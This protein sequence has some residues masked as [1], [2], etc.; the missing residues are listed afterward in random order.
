MIFFGLPSDNYIAVVYIVPENSN[1]A[2]HDPFGLLQNDIACIPPGCQVL[3]CGDYNAHTSVESDFMVNINE[4]WDGELTDYL[5]N[6]NSER[7]TKIFAM[8]EKNPLER[9]SQDRRNVDNYGK[10]LLK[11]CKAVGMLILNGRLGADKGIGRY[12]RM[13][14]NSAS[15]VDYVIVTPDLFDDVGQFQ[16]NNKF[17]ESDHLYWS[18]IQEH[19]ICSNIMDHLE[20]C[21]I[22]SDDQH[23]FRSGL[24]TETQLLA[25]SHDWAEVIDRGGQTDV[26]S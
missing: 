5:C 3:L 19:I 20:R 22:L 18:K 1:Y 17:H 16:V 15:V 13:A 2:R 7:S 14:D 10:L 11:L 6:I 23:G 9:F 8:M 24:S 25:A 21:G 4:G 26:L 12:T